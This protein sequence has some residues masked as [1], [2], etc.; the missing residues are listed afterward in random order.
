MADEI[1]I[2]VGFDGKYKELTVRIPDGDVPPYQP[3]DKLAVVGKSEKRL[4]AMAKATGTAKYSYDQRPSG[5]LYGAVLRCPHANANVTVLDTTTA[6]QMPGVKAVVKATDLFES[7]SCRYAGAE[8][9]AVAATSEAIAEEA[10]RSIFVE[11]DV[12]P[13]A[14]TLEDSMAAGAPQ[15]GRG[16]QENVART[17]PRTP[18]RR[19]GGIDEDREEQIQAELAEQEHRVDEIFK[20]AHKVV[21]RTFRTQV[22]THCPL[23]P[24]GL[25][26]EWTDGKLVAWAS[27]QAVFGVQF[28]LGRQ[29]GTSPHVIC[30]HVGGGF[31]SKFSAGREGVL[32]A[33][34]ARDAGAP[35]RLMLDR[36]AEQTAVGNR[37]DSKQKLTMGVDRNGK[38]LALR[39]RSCGTPGT[40]LNGAGAHNDAIYDLGEIDKIE[41]GVRTNTGGARAHRAPGWPQGSFALESIIDEAAD[42]IGLDPIEMRRRN[43]N[44]PIRKAEY[45]IAA[46][47]SKW[48][49]KRGKSRSDGPVKRGI[50]AASTLWFSAGGGGASVLVRVH[51]S[52]RVEVRNGA[53]D[54]GTG[55]RTVMGQVAA[56][57]LGLGLDDVEVFIGDS[58][59]PRGPASGGSTTIGTI[60]PAARIAAHRAKRELLEI[61][62]DRK[63]WNASE[64]DLANGAVVDSKGKARLTFAAA[65]ALLE[66]DAIEALERRP[67]LGRRRAN[68]AGLADTNAGVQVAEVAVDTET[69]EIA[70]E[71]VTAVAD[72]GKLINPKL[73]ESQVRG[74]VIQGV[75]YALFERRTMDRQEGRMVNADMESYKILGA[76]DCPEIDVSLLD[77]Y[78]GKNNTSTMGLGEPPI[79]ATAAAI[80]NAVSEA[81]GVRIDSIP[82]TPRKVLE[83]LGKVSKPAQ[84]AAEE[85]EGTK[86]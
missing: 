53:Q 36:R 2:Q 82:I 76:A 74:G 19:G 83:A 14:V 77:V 6:E 86:L 67:T 11:Y 17:S 84:K 37:P 45:D 81:I 16:S 13:F 85:S 54:I 20:G 63:G 50:G 21:S 42:A 46:K 51:K 7:K 22:Q 32:G 79:V 75:S 26:C 57:E 1:Q 60:T 28:E 24:H 29:L 48:S 10:L 25:V 9:A 78:M 66:E 71:R 34:L 80:S 35:V 31:G 61:V 64:L 58:N 44:H 33:T 39:V 55:T 41:W 69:G 70:V 3:N 27:T 4:D 40:G 52:G 43:D 56:E 65:C 23:E 68:Y 62:A 12:L 30:E 59:D 73:A 5:M 8:V 47:R 38:I 49:E 18:R 15:V 72:G